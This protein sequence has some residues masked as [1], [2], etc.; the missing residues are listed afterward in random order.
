MLF[1]QERVNHY[2]SELQITRMAREKQ[3]KRNKDHLFGI[4]A[5]NEFDYHHNFFEGGVNRD[6][7]FWE[8]ELVNNYVKKI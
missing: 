2:A 5:Y 3:N 4:Q 7:K 1:L 8:P 6:M